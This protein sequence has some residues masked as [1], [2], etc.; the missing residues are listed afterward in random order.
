MSF[1]MTAYP[2][3]R[4]DA[5]GQLGSRTLGRGRVRGAEAGAQWSLLCRLAPTYRTTN[6]R[7]GKPQPR[8]T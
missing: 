8:H 2:C 5:R 3:Q 7:P 4:K 6:L 1:E